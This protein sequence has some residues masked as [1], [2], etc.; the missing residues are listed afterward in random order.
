MKSKLCQKR[1]QISSSLCILPIPD[2]EKANT[3]FQIK[4]NILPWSK[5]KHFWF[6][7]LIKLEY[8]HIPADISVKGAGIYLHKCS[9]ARS[10]HVSSGWTL[11]VGG[12][13]VRDV[14]LI[15]MRCTQLLSLWLCLNLLPAPEEDT[16][17]SPHLWWISLIHGERACGSKSWCWRR[18]VQGGDATP[19]G[20]AE[21]RVQ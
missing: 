5:K 1:G 8:L 21:W 14:R 19:P 4:Q 11:K 18:T 16:D 12:S 3:M 10:N 7:L 17:N 15:L 20:H 6:S 9:Y 13:L 2:M